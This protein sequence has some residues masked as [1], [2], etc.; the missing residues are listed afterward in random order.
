MPKHVLTILFFSYLVFNF[1]NSFA[2]PNDDA[3]VAEEFNEDPTVPPIRSFAYGQFNKGAS[4]NLR[5][6]LRKRRSFLLPVVEKITQFIITNY[7]KN[8]P[9]SSKPVGSLQGSNSASFEDSESEASYILRGIGEFARKRKIFGADVDAESR[10]VKRQKTTGITINPAFRASKT[11]TSETETSIVNKL[12]DVTDL[13]SSV[14]EVAT[15]GPKRENFTTLSSL[16]E[17]LLDRFVYQIEEIFKN[18]CT[19][20]SKQ[21]SEG[22]RRKRSLYPSGYPNV[23]TTNRF[24]AKKVNNP[25]KNGT[26]A[27]QP[28]SNR[29]EF[30]STTT[31]RN[32]QESG[33]SPLTSLLQLPGNIVTGALNMSKNAAKTAFKLV[34]PDREGP[35]EVYKRS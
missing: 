16:F 7:V 28:V 13:I 14:L 15:T 10:R 27:G 2:A 29:R 9:R 24:L 25:L 31:M 12:T 22:F 33:R 5:L 11:P 20:D 21:I 30:T 19:L 32:P 17:D 8:V 6:L 23:R 1:E 26:A 4:G 35:E 34:L 3:E 18:F